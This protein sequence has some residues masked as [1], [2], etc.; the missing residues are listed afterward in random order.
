MSVADIQSLDP[1]FRGVVM[2]ELGARCD[3]QVDVTG[4]DEEEAVRRVIEAIGGLP[5]PL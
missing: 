3:L 1:V 4:A 5:V 2:A